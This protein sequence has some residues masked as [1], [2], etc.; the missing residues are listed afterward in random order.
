MGPEC[1]ME[2]SFLPGGPAKLALHAALCSGH[3]VPERAERVDYSEVTAVKLPIAVAV[4]VP[5]PPL[6]GQSPPPEKSMGQL[7]VPMPL[8]ICQLFPLSPHLSFSRPP[9][10]KSVI[11]RSS[12]SP[13]PPPVAPFRGT[14][15]C[16]SP[17][18][19]PIPT[20]TL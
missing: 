13:F 16:L 1:G 3:S 4:A 7:F 14:F 10:N 9:T 19:L 8:P 15:S 12:N 5:T 20:P 17:L 18:T 11:S 6:K 2:G